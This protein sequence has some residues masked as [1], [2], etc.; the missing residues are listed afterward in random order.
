MGKE[1]LPT[2]GQSRELIGLDITLTISEVPVHL[3]SQLVQILTVK[4]PGA[5]VGKVVEYSVSGEG[6]SILLVWS[7]VD[8]FPIIRKW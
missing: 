3:S 6:T 7:K 4:F 8:Y 5:V 2:I 1:I